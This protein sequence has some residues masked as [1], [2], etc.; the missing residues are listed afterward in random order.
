M[1][2]ILL[3]IIP[4]IVFFIYIT[5]TKAEKT[6]KYDWQTENQYLQSDYTLFYNNNT[7][8]QKGYVTSTIN[9]ED[10]DENDIPKTYIYH[11]NIQGELQ[12]TKILESKMILSMTTNDKYIVAL[13]KNYL[14]NQEGYYISLL[15]EE[16]ET[17][18][19][20]H[21][22]LEDDEEIDYI[23]EEFKIL[24]LKYINIIDN[25]AY[26]YT[27]NFIK[28]INLDTGS[29]R[30]MD[31]VG[32]ITDVYY[33]H[34][35][36]L[37]KEKTETKTY[38]GYE[39]KN[40]K[41]VLTGMD[42]QG[43]IQSPVSNEVGGLI[44]NSILS[45]YPIFTDSF[46]APYVACNPDYKAILKIYNKENIVLEKT[47]KDYSI[48]STPHIINDYIVTIATKIDYDTYNFQISILILDMKGNI[49]QE[50][51]EEDYYLSLVAGPTS[52]MTIGTNPTNENNCYIEEKEISYNCFKNNNIVY[53]LPLSINTKIQG[54]GTIE[55]P[56]TARYE[57]LI[58]YYPIPKENHSLEKITIID[59]LNNEIS[60]SNNTFQMPENNVTIIATFGIENPQT[61]DPSKI[62]LLFILVI[63]SIISLKVY[64]RKR[65]II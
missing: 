35:D 48:F 42:N 7:Y 14:S 61:S 43:C 55:V 6:F 18:K 10:R 20:I 1:K 44:D 33:K 2:K 24:G 64:K 12:K 65:E 31:P 17:I 28:G 40:N 21:I 27:S 11:Y 41:I 32:G 29:I 47:Y 49:L 38:L 58:K 60:Y 36:T 3:S 52:F 53:Y 5:P 26:I 51:K 9:L 46:I 15:N 19:E 50:I 45:R 63:T 4:I 34:I 13:I 54:E 30:S 39:E 23:L 16:L 22:S 57:E 62:I 8:Y 37:E 59:S 25:N 56:S